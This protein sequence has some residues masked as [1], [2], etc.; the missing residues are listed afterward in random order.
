[1]KS[2]NQNTSDNIERRELDLVLKFLRL[3][4]SY[5]VYFGI[6][7]S[8]TIIVTV[9]VLTLI[10]NRYTARAVILPPPGSSSIPSS[11]AG[12]ISSV[13]GGSSSDGTISVA[14]YPSII[15][16]R[17]VLDLVL[18]SKYNG[19][20]VK[21]ILT[22][23]DSIS[24]EDEEILFRNLQTDIRVNVNGINNSVV[25]LYEN[26][27]PE[28][29]AFFL[30]CII[31]QTDY[32]FRSLLQSSARDQRVML[33]KRILDAQASLHEAEEL[34]NTFRQRNKSISNSSALML[35]QQQ[36]E[37][38]YSIRSKLYS[39]LRKQRELIKI[40]EIEDIQILQVLDRAIV[41]SHKSF[42]M[43]GRILLGVIYIV[44][45]LMTIFIKL[46]DRFVIRLPM[47]Q[48]FKDT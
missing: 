36:L 19:K 7:I 39:D 46:R 28:F 30:N 33:E 2:E 20:R 41:P 22:E 15:H 9:V 47:K 45:V 26:E 44:I 25:L 6:V 23:K 18:N 14:L 24:Y 38:D 32:L 1:M 29:A 31:E 5:K 16:S 11:L 12:I 21:Y 40:E 8:I 48:E 10:P 42:P 43:R 13:S 37:L 3:M 4:W 17:S 34:L 35:R 27:D